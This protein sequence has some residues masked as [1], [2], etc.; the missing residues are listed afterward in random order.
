MGFSP[1][2]DTC[3]IYSV[4]SRV[5]TQNETSEDRSGS[6]KLARWQFLTG[7]NTTPQTLV[8]LIRKTHKQTQCLDETNRNTGKETEGQPKEVSPPPYS[9][10]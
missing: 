7:V 5:V 4:P 3:D 8:T 2:Y 6:R 1:K 10:L 9:S